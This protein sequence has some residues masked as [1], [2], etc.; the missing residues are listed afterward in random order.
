L[1]RLGGFVGVGERMA[2]PE[3]TPRLADRLRSLAVSR[4]QRQAAHSGALD[5]RTLG[6]LALDAG[7]A[8]IIIILGARGAYDLWIVAL[9]LLGLSLGLAIK[10]LRL[11][12]AEQIGPFIGD[13]LNARK[14]QD[15]R[16]LEEWLLNDLT[17]DVET[18]D[19]AL[20]R[21]A[22]LFDQALTFLVLAILVELTGKLG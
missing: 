12:G 3:T 17:D 16:T 6:V 11:P 2:T 5:A 13:V 19:E 9:V 10:T 18:N 20:A 4:L 8:A 22:R 21:K 1:S 15:D 7:V 14:T